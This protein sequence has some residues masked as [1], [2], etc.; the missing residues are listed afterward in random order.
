MGIASLIVVEAE[1]SMSKTTLF[2]FFLINCW[3]SVVCLGLCLPQ[4]VQI[5]NFH[6]FCV[7]TSQKKGGKKMFD[8]VV[9]RKGRY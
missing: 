9:L 6:F 8:N 5:S 3:S 4:L 2:F 7:N 1:R